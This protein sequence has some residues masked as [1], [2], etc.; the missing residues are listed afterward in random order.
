MSDIFQEV[1]EAL[2]QE[3]L[4]KIWQ[5]YQ[6]PIIAGLAALILGTAGFTG[7]SN[8]N[9]A[10]NAAQTGGLLSAL[11]SETPETALQSFSEDTRNNHETIAQ[12]NLARLMVEEGKTTQAAEIYKSVA[13][14]KRTHKDIRDL[15]RVLFVRNSEKS[16]T[17]IL[18]PVLSNEK[19]P[20]IWHARLEAAL[21]EAHH[22]ENLQEAISLLQKFDKEALIPAS[23]KQRASA[24]KSVYE[25]KL[26][27]SSSPSSSKDKK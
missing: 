18:L 7:F 26:G 1:D 13:A 22:N 2:Q 16:D 19:S 15:A 6:T 8:W 12:L 10:Q 17:N 5:E 25:H 23:L 14:N 4:A 3:K 27:S 11:D 20:W 9:T 21:I 24:L